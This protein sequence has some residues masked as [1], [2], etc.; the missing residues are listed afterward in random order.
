V[1]DEDEVKSIETELVG[2]LKQQ[3]SGKLATGATN[4]STNSS[5]SFTASS[6]TSSSSSTG[7]CVTTSSPLAS[8]KQPP[9]QSVMEE[10][11]SKSGPIESPN[12]STNHFAFIIKELNVFT[13]SQTVRSDHQ[14]VKSSEIDLQLL[15]KL[16]DLLSL[17]QERLLQLSLNR[18]H[19]SS[20]NE[21]ESRAKEPA[22]NLNPQD[23]EEIKKTVQELKNKMN[24]TRTCVEDY[25]GEMN[26][27]L[28]QL[29]AQT[30]NLASTVKNEPAVENEIRQS[31][32]S[33]DYST[34]F[35]LIQEKNLLEQGQEGELNEQMSVSGLDENE[36]LFVSRMAGL[37]REQ[38]ASHLKEIEELKASMQAMKV[39]MNAEKQ[40][41]FN[42][43][44]KRVAKEKDRLI[45]DL[46]A[47]Q[48]ECLTRVSQLEEELEKY[49]QAAASST[50][51]TN[52]VRFVYII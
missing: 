26:A 20:R 34:L 35:G 19:E 7:A 28:K 11:L 31:K 41:M 13:Q 47:R 42:E 22:R 33:V 45:E 4:Q 38:K 51:T 44:I 14:D 9:M 43:A 49:R 1:I 29:V 39:N 46:R 12:H 30:V 2:F 24:E 5:V 23:P 6:S 3:A 10:D 36:R 16:S 8:D 18:N 40:I 48:S 25:Q 15:N 50:S 17:D 52:K 37:V 32:Q 21:D 27:Y